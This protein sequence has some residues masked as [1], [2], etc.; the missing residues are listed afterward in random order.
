MLR[1]A[2]LALLLILC[3][4]EDRNQPCREACD[5]EAACDAG[6]V[7]D[8]ANDCA[9]VVNYECMTCVSIRSCS[10]LAADAGSCPCTLR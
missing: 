5:H 1:R 7:M 6:P 2:A 4:C 8:C 9:R 10:E 3:A